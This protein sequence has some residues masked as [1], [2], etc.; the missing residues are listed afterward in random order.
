MFIQSFN[1]HSLSPRHGAKPKDPVG[2]EPNTV[3][4]PAQSRMQ[5]RDSFISTKNDYPYFR[6]TFS[7]Y[8]SRIQKNIDKQKENG[9]LLPRGNF[10]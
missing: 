9:L 7:N 6:I 2:Q 5:D 10:S 1:K 4:Q 3:S 8:I